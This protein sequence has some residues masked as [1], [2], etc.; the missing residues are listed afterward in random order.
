LRFLF[1]QL[2]PS[3][4]DK[5][6]FRSTFWAYFFDDGDADKSVSDKIDHLMHPECHPSS[7][8]LTDLR[9]GSPFSCLT[10]EQRDIALQV[11]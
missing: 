4:S 1:A 3:V 10:E 11:I 8:I 6:R 7:E 5:K 9:H 2:A